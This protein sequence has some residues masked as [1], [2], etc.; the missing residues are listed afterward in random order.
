MSSGNFPPVRALLAALLLAVFGA[1]EVVAEEPGWSKFG[2]RGAYGYSRA[3]DFNQYEV[4]AAHSM[5]LSFSF[6]DD[7]VA[8]S[9]W[10]MSAGRLTNDEIEALVFTAGPVMVIRKR[11]QP[12]SIEIGSRPTIISDHTFGKV[13]Y[14]GPFQFTSHAGIG[15]RFRELELAY[16][17]Q[18]MSNA[19]IYK[20]NDGLDIHVVEVGWR[21]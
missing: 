6:S 2:F 9:Y 12:W 13:D 14:G 15:W 7:W 11:E 3:D 4:F 20:R 10:E 16:R 8:Q 19:S 18:H 5:R 1:G 17:I 21:F